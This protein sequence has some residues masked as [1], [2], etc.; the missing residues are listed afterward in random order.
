M[1]PIKELLQRRRN[2]REELSPLKSVCNFRISPGGT[3]FCNLCETLLEAH[4]PDEYFHNRVTRKYYAV[5]D[6][7][8]DRVRL[9]KEKKKRKMKTH[10]V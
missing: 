5:R 3:P 8:I 1:N 9:K 2:G 10:A 4:Y 6:I 7:A